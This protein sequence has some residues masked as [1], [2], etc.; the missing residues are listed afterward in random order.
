MKILKQLN[1]CLGF[2]YKLQNKFF[3][4]YATNLAVLI[5]S[6]RNIQ[7]LFHRLKQ[8]K[9]NFYFTVKSLLTTGKHKITANTCANALLCKYTMYLPT[10]G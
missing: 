1:Y 10:R 3:P 4:K 6:V 5:W 9:T 8:W 7:M 2:N